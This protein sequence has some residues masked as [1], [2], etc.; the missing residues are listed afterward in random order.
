MW[1]FFLEIIVWISLLN[2]GV[3]QS[4]KKDDVLHE[5][6]NPKQ[7]LAAHST[8]QKTDASTTEQKDL[9]LIVHCDI[10]WEELLLGEEIG[11]GMSWSYL[12]AT[13]WQRLAI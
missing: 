9:N 12:N 5:Q 7:D 1:H 11:E 3:K 2:V 13:T 10:R 4:G 8:L 6:E